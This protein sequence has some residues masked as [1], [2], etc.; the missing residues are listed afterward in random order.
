MGNE[1]IYTFVIHYMKSSIFMGARYAFL[2]IPLHMVCMSLLPFPHALS[3]V[4]CPTRK[5]VWGYP[6]VRGVTAWY[7]SESRGLS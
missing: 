5:V 3:L 4:Y 1:Y 6:R 7:Q 2:I